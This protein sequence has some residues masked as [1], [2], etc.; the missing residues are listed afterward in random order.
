MRGSTIQNERH[1]SEYLAVNAKYTKTINPFFL[2]K[3]INSNK[4]IISFPS[5]KNRNHFTSCHLTQHSK[6]Y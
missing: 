2:Q 6:S 5:Y 4:L 1:T 3:K